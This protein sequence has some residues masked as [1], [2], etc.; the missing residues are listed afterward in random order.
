MGLSEIL[1][2]FDRNRYLL[3]KDH[4]LQVEMGMLV[5]KSRLLLILED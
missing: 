3:L 2:N 1:F 5:V 4:V